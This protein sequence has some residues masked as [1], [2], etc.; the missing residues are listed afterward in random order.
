MHS[1][2]NADDGYWREDQRQTCIIGC[3]DTYAEGAEIKERPR[4]AYDGSLLCGKCFARLRRLVRAMDGA[5]DW[6]GQR[7]ARDGGAGR[8][9]PVS[10]TSE[11][12]LPLREAL[13]DHREW[14]IKPRLA[15]WARIVIDEFPS[16]LAGPRSSHPH[17]VAGWL[18]P[19]LPWVAAQPWVDEMLAELADTVS[20]AHKLAPW[21]RERRHLDLPCPECDM[22]SLALFGGDDWI[23]CQT[24][25]CGYWLPWFR[26]AKIAKQIVALHAREKA[27]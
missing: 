12:R 24:P 23:T 16:P 8:F 3:T 6:L 14:A 4:Q 10:G 5:Y 13:H 17:D 9:E 7:M 26:Y 15:G 19:H 2:P 21:Q 27:S 18:L 1:D 25:T 20:D 22:L 11:A